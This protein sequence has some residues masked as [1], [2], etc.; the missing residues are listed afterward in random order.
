MSVVL[1][2]LADGL[3]GASIEL[4]QDYGRARL[5]WIVEHAGLICDGCSRWLKCGRFICQ[6]TE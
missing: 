1:D 2:G 3:L 4:R 5:A 6:V